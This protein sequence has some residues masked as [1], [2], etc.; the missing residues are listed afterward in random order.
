VKAFRRFGAVGIPAN[1]GTMFGFKLLMVAGGFP[2]EPQFPHSTPVSPLLQRWLQFITQ[3]VEWG[4]GRGSYPDTIHHRTAAQTTSEGLSR[5]ETGRFLGKLVGRW[6]S[7][8]GGAYQV[9]ESYGGDDETR[10]RD[11]CRD[12]VDTSTTYNNLEGYWGLPNT[13]KYIV[14]EPLVG[15]KLG[16]EISHPMTSQCPH[17][18]LQCFPEGAP[19]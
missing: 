1:M 3:T 13:S 18:L 2:F 15:L 17:Q 8:L 5:R 11:L 4:S 12:R 16:L 19:K 7:A 14:A 10:T 9:T 6:I